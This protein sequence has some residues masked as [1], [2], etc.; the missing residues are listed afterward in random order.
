MLPFPGGCIKVN[1]DMRAMLQCQFIF[2]GQGPSKQAVDWGELRFAEQ[3]GV[4][5][6]V[7]GLLWMQRVVVD[8]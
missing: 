5:T 6:L 4:D 7:G 2:E 8:S 1:L 3:T